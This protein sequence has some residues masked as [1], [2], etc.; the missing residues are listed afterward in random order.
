M[1]DFYASVISAIVSAAIGVDLKVI[2]KSLNKEKLKK[3]SNLEISENIDTVSKK[4]EESKEIIDN[5]LLEMDKQKK[6]FE[7]MKKEAEISQQISN[8]NN[9]QIAALNEVLEKTLNNQDRKSLPK[10]LF[11]NFFFCILSAVIGF[12]LGKL[13]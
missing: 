11:I 1:L 4:L 2:R 7:Q 6:L 9:E 8:M 5:A 13:F 12:A 10:N 3:S